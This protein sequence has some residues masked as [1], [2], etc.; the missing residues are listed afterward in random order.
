[1]AMAA[2]GGV[3]AVGEMDQFVGDGYF[4]GLWLHVWFDEDEMAMVW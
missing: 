2:R 1:M 4:D 3:N